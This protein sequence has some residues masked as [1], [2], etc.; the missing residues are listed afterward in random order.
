MADGLNSAVS[1]MKTAG[2]G[3]AWGMAVLAAY[4]AFGNGKALPEFLETDVFASMGS[5][6]VQPDKKGSE[7]FAKF[8]ENYKKGLS[9]EYAAAQ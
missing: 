2:E 6:T 7:G 9:A 4:A 8:I 5:T 3:G 1:V